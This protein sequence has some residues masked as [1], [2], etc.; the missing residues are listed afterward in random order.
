LFEHSTDDLDECLHYDI[1][2]SKECHG[3]CRFYEA[4]KVDMNQVSESTELQNK[5]NQKT[6]SSTVSLVKAIFEE[7]IPAIDI[8]KRIAARDLEEK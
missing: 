3:K 2:C 6:I 4:A 5:K 8:H 7:V 1:L